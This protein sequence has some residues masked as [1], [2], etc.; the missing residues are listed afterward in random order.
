VQEKSDDDEDDD[1]NPL[2]GKSLVLSEELAL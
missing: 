2:E 1:E